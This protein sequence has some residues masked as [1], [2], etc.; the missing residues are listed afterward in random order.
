MAKRNIKETL[1][2]TLVHGEETLNNIDVLHNLNRD[3]VSSTPT[4][5]PC[6]RI[7]PSELHL[8]VNEIIDTHQGAKILRFVSES[9]YLPPFQAGQYINIVFD[10]DGARTTRPYSLSS[11]PKER[12]YY[13]ITVAEIKDGYVSDYVLNHVQVGDHFLSSGPA[14]HFVYNAAF[15]KKKSL[16]LAGGSSIT[17]FLSMVRDILYSGEDRDIVLLYGARNLHV[18]IYHDELTRLSKEFPNFAYQLVL[19]EAEEGYEGEKGFLDERI[20]R[21]YAPDFQERTAY[22]SGPNVMHHFCKDTLLK[23][24]L[25]QKDI[26]DEVFGSSSDITK[27]E[28]WPKEIDGNQIFKLKVGDQVVDAKAGE[29]I[30]VA[31]ER[32]GIRV[33][34]CCRSGECSLCRVKLVSGKVYLANGMLLRLA[35]S[36]FGYIHSCKSYP[37]SDLE[38]EF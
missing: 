3:L 18:A 31:L 17:P 23:M 38:I 11:S 25:K 36:K 4:D 5:S 33:N 13:E 14:G 16:F 12:G 37:N 15:H 2:S 21:K 20:I 1:L 32:A 26:R 9:G 28:G 22:I 6:K 29:S 10:I 30:L 7:H 34:V 8:I 27:E 24:G 19:S 35:D